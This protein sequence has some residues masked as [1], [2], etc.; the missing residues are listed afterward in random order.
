[1]LGRARHLHLGAFFMSPTLR[2]DVPRLFAEARRRGLS[3]SLDTNYDP[4]EGWDG[5]LSAA[6]AHV[7]LFLPNETEL[8]A[9]GGS[10]D[11]DQALER[12][13]A[14]ADRRGQAWRAAAW[15]ARATQSHA[16]RPC[17]S[18][19]PTPPARAMFWTLGSCMAL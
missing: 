14:R 19:W 6:L 13:A 15:R 9:I 16:H 17:R 18:R 4:A 11:V 7:D 2:S 10:P 12:L 8:C 1:M 3:I 5:G